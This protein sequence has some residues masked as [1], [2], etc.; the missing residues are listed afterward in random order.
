ML[1]GNLSQVRHILKLPLQFLSERMDSDDMS[2]KIGS[3]G[4]VAGNSDGVASLYSG[5]R[6]QFNNSNKY[7]MSDLDKQSPQNMIHDLNSEE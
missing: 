5:I 2:G 1:S 6:N 3:G 7:L 4:R